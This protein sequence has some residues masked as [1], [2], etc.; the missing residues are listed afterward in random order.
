MSKSDKLLSQIINNPRDV[1]FDDL[2][3]LLIRY[4]FERRQSRRGSSHYTYSHS[5][6]VDILTIPFNRPVNVEYVKR[7]I[8]AIQKVDMSAD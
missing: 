2:N 7:A 1:R 3:K 4:G 6:L 5:N 8:D